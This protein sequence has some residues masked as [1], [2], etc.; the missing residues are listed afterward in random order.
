MIKTV[1]V[2]EKNNM[3][4]EKK[5]KSHWNGLLGKKKDTKQKQYLKRNEIN[6]PEIIVM[7]K[8]FQIT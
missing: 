5:K 2:T 8:A 3:I 4:N 1:H 6:K 7:I